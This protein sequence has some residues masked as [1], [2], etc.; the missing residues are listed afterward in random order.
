MKLPK[1]LE[2]MVHNGLIEQV[3][4][5][6]TSGK[7]A[8][9]YVVYSEGE[10][11]CA[12]VYKEITKRNFKKQSSY[13]E[14]R[15][16]RNSRQGRAMEKRSK[17]GRKE[18]ESAW[19]NA[20]V[21]A[22]YKVAAIGVRVPEPYYCMDGVLLMELII[23]ENGEVAPRLQDLH[24]SEELAMDY[25]SQ[26]IVDVMHMLCAGI[27]H[28]D[29]SEYNVLVDSF[30]PVI[31]D[32]PQAVDAVN[33]NNAGKFLIRD[34]DNLR[35]FFSQ[36]APALKKT[37]YGKEMWSI[38]KAGNLT[39][40]TPLTGFFKQ[41]KKDINVKHVMEAIDEAREEAEFERQRK[42]IRSL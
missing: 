22:L 25:F 36:Y 37:E 1:R 4:K 19:Q 26:L 28:G 40:E 9:I 8:D 41:S 34:L 15:K 23:G 2:G 30:G 33:N 11:R 6:L 27:V 10:Y 29:L 7:E 20:E 12:K 35:D 18:I 17:Y 3:I 42:A 13:Q 38:Y 39:P 16:V 21:D 5:R 32:L 14:G 24:L 31:I